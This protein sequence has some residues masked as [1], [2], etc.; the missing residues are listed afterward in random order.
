MC[1]LYIQ[2]DV[3]LF[4]SMSEGFGYPILEA[5]SHGLPVITRNFGA[6]KEVAGDAAM[7]L[8]QDSSNLP[9]LIMSLN[10]EEH[11]KNLVNKGYKNVSRFSQEK[12]GKEMLKIYHSVV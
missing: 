10:E 4:D 8:S 5:M 12:F 6:M 3:L 11:I 2:S 9:D 1:S 7:F